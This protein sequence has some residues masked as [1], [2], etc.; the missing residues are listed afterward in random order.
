MYVGTRRLDLN[1]KRVKW[2]LSKKN[3]TLTL[4]YLV[5]IFTCFWCRILQESCLHKTQMGVVTYVYVLR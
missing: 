5:I 4:R 1:L 2:T 3:Y